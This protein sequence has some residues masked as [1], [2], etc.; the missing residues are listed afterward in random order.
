[1][2]TPEHHETP[3]FRA[4]ALLL[5]MLSLS[6]GW[7]IRGNFGHEFG[8]M[9][10]GTLCAIAVCLLS[11]RED[12]QRRAL[13][14]GLFGAIGW[15]F[16]G[17]MSYMQVVSYTHSG[18]LPS[19]IYGF[20][21]VFVLGFLWASL[22]GAGTAY[23]AVETRERLT[24]LLK[25]LTVVFVLWGVFYFIE[26]PMD[27]WYNRL[28]FGSEDA[29]GLSGD[30]GWFRQKSPF[31]WLDTD[32]IQAL[33]AI[34]AVCLYDVW[35]RW[36]SREEHG[37]GWVGE[38]FL[39]VTLPLLG[40]CVGWAL[41]RAL[42]H[43]VFLEDFLAYVVQPQGDVNAPIR[44][45]RDSIERLTSGDFVTNW[46]QFFF[47][48]GGHLGW[49][50]GALFGFALYFA[51][52]GRWRSGSSLIL[53]MAV[54]WYVAFLSMP[55]LLSPWFAE[56]G[57]FRMTPPR[58]DNWA[59]V[60]GVLAGLMVYM[61]RHRLG[62]VNVAA[63]VSGLIGG[64]G[65]MFTQ[66][67]KLMLTAIGNPVLIGESEYWRHWQGANWH[68]LV[69]E[70][71][72]GL[73][74]GLG[75]AVAL[76]LLSLR[77]PR[78]SDEP[79]VRPWAESYAAIFLLLVL[80]Y[81]NVVKNVP[82]FTADRAPN[83]P[84]VTATVTNPAALEE[85]V[86]DWEP[87]GAVPAYRLVPQEMRMPLVQSVRLSAWTWFTLIYLLM[88]ACAVALAAAHRRRP[89]AVV[90]P[91]PVGKGQLVYLLFL[92]ALVVANFERAL[93]GFT[94]QRLV[95]EGLITV[96][97]VIVTFL[98]LTLVRGSEPV[99]AHE[100]RYA[101]LGAKAAALGLVAVLLSAFVYVGGVRLV[102][103]DRHTGHA[104]VNMRFGGEA[105]WYVKPI[106]KNRPHQ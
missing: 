79:R 81:V 16:G 27:Y 55:V 40:A 4:P 94:E 103:G 86:P 29:A 97:A 8:A 22:G 73:F 76:G 64:L 51:L 21:G 78:V 52:F 57:G 106:L 36:T 85:A 45:A 32:W 34:V 39:L 66:F 75:V 88:A 44:V 5:A 23:P 26:D 48:I 65:F 87:D 35:D 99:P 105:D 84:G 91:T 2:A 46:P 67:L 98:L 6:I 104:G 59:G 9:I 25:P 58:G 30:T 11:G 20:F 19:Q 41:Q 18:H 61:A 13:F 74:Y 77:A 80:T 33:L 15:G 101:S 82:E 71:G 96:N 72:V 62:A 12:W 50:F 56:V 95:T 38:A 63:L 14:F 93:P 92:W 10:A 68:S 60:V 1:M 28:V 24:G 70:Q 49:I 69:I 54:G 83:I 100:P 47:D 42:V 7:G 90:P 89:L 31:Y 102:Y 53:H 17:S 3:A 37:L 43:S